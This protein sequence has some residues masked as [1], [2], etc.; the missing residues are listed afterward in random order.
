VQY[1]VQMEEVMNANR[2]PATEPSVRQL[3]G[4]AEVHRVAAGLLPEKLS[5]EITAA[6]IAVA[7][8]G[9][10]DDPLATALNR[11]HP[12][13]NKWWTEVYSH[14]N[15]L[16]E[17]GAWVPGTSMSYGID[18]AT[19]AALQAL[20]AGQLFQ[21]TVAE[22]TADKEPDPIKYAGGW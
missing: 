18:A 2:K 11:L 5:V 14:G 6:D 10:T 4:I 16:R 13:T 19:T 22:L 15:K 17:G 20:D 1:N 7:G 12:S 9:N 21:P 8:K 3:E